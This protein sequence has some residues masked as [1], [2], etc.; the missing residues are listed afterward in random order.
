MVHFF[1]KGFLR[2]G[3]GNNAQDSFLKMLRDMKA[4]GSPIDFYFP[5]TNDMPLLD[6]NLHETNV[7]NNG[8]DKRLS[9]LAANSARICSSVRGIVELMNSRLHALKLSGNS[10]RIAWQFCQRSG[11]KILS[12]WIA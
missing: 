10:K 4:N 9:D 11:L 6:Q 8:F 5:T 12:W 1:D 3:W 7:R 2:Y